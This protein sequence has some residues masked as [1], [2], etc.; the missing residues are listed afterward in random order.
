MQR[1]C[2][3]AFALNVK[4]LAAATFTLDIRVP[5]A[6]GLIQAV[7]DE[8]DLVPIDELQS[9]RVDDNLYALVLE[10]NVVGPDFLGIIDDVGIARTAGRSD[11]EAQTEVVFTIFEV[12]ADALSRRICKRY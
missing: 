5:E 10:H 7:F 2:V 12:R 8:I 6:E 1:G 9:L 11:A 3:E 4:A